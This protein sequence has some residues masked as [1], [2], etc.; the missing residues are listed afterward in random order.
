MNIFCDIIGNRFEYPSFLLNLFPPGYLALRVPKVRDIFWVEASD[1][2]N[3]S[4]LLR[5]P[6][7]LGLDIKFARLSPAKT[8]YPDKVLAGSETTFVTL[9]ATPR[10]KQIRSNS[11]VAPA[12]R[13]RGVK[14][15]SRSPAEPYGGYETRR[16]ESG[17]GN[18]GGRP[19]LT[20]VFLNPPNGS[21]GIDFS[22][23][24]SGSLFT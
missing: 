8:F 1:S 18:L 24:A 9:I 11:T 14:K 23:L 15:A 17:G 2:A 3:P 22:N 7:K 20:C 5:G 6:A 10:R 4:G 13:V 16:D 19:K 12:A 21:G